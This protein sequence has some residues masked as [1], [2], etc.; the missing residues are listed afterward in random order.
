MNV[1]RCMNL[2]GWSVPDD[3]CLA[4]MF[5]RRPSVS[6]RRIFFCIVVIASLSTVYVN[7]VLRASSDEQRPAGHGVI[8]SG[9]VSSSPSSSSRSSSPLPCD[10]ECRRSVSTRHVI[11]S[12]TVSGSPSSPS[13]STLSSLP[14]DA[15]CRRFR[16]LLLSW[17]AHRPKAAIV[18]LLKPSSVNTF[19][20]SSRLFSANFN[21]QYGYPV[22]IFH[23]ES[24]N[25]EADR[26]RLRSL[27]NSSLYF[28]VCLSSALFYQITPKFSH[29]LP[30]LMGATQSG[31]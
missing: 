29:C 12:G 9:T 23:E 19:G 3:R 6:L 25:N 8:V 24:M 21:D 14:C 27:S 17:P 22:I 5:G 16:Q 28:Q 18:L 2:L 31:S 15:E 11:V 26:Q 13:T 1:Q 7:L 4:W 20:R 30:Y 10:A